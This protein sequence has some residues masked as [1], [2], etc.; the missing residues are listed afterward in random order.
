MLRIENRLV[1]FTKIEETVADTEKFL[2]Y[3][4]PLRMTHM[5]YKNMIPMHKDKEQR[6]Q[7][8]EST[9]ETMKDLLDDL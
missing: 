5:I 6:L 2:G 8:M 1:D 9:Q 7:L 4:L 3:V